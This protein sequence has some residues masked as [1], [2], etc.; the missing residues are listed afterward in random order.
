MRWFE[1][2]QQHGASCGS[3]NGHRAE[4]VGRAHNLKGKY[5]FLK[6]PAQRVTDFH[7]ETWELFR[8]THHRSPDVP[9]QRWQRTAGLDEMS[10]LPARTV[11]GFGLIEEET[12][13]LAADMQK[14]KQ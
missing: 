12:Y 10:R 3:C 8:M 5:V 2:G 9:G 11:D 13:L 14:D 7:R 1:L 6:C 4:C